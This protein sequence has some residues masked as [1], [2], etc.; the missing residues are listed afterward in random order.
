MVS[1]SCKDF[2]TGCDF[3]ARAADI[4]I[5]IPL[6]ADHAK[7][8]HGYKSLPPELASQIRDQARTESGSRKI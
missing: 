1:I 3:I 4:D 2:G 6:V 7:K 5:L 8:I